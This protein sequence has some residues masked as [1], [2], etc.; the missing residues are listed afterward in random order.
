MPTITF[1][2]SDLWYNFAWLSVANSFSM[3]F[4]AR[5]KVN[6]QMSLTLMDSLPFPRFA[7]EERTAFLVNRAAALS[8]CGTEMRGALEQPARAGC[9]LT[10]LEP[11]EEEDARLR[12]ISK[13]E[14]FIAL[15]VYGLSREELDHVMESFSGTKKRD[16]KKYGD[17]RTKVFALENYGRRQNAVETGEPRPVAGAGPAP[18]ETGSCADGGGRSC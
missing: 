8:C 12:E 1:D 3:D 15:R 9:D 10:G 14:A 7:R 18:A 5:K 11:I 2:D 4:L 16:I 6:L 17:Y 13:L